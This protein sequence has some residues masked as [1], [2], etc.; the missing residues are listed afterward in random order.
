MAYPAKSLLLCLSLAIGFGFSGQIAFA[1]VAS[2]TRVV[3]VTPFSYSEDGVPQNVKDEMAINVDLPRDIVRY[4]RKV[5]AFKSVDLKKSDSAL[6]S[7]ADL[8]V[9]GEILYVTGGSGAKRYFP[10]AGENSDGRAS[11]LLEIKVFDGRNELLYEARLSQAG[12][13]GTNIITAWS[14]KENIASA[15]RVLP[16]QILPIV[17][18]GDITTPEGVIRSVQSGNAL[19]IRLAAISSHTHELFRDAEVTDTMERTVLEAVN[20]GKIDREFIDGLAWCLTN[21]GASGDKKYT[22]SLVK[23]IKSDAHSKLKRFAKKAYKNLKSSS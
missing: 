13:R 6:K 5:N 23:I 14:N 20:N 12:T 4:L 3:V 22:A 18:G 16:E 17:I 10:T 15:V 2:E 21:L 1:A 19:A 9:R 7:E 8:F 11:I